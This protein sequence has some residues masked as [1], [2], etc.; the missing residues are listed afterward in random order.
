MS[1]SRTVRSFM[2]LPAAMMAVAMILS[3]GAPSTAQAGIDKYKMSGKWLSRRG[4]AFIPLMAAAAT[5]A[6]IGGCLGGD[7]NPCYLISGG[8]AG[9]GVAS[10]TGA[11]VGKQL[12]IP[13]GVFDGQPLHLVPLG[14]GTRN[15]FGLPANPTVIQVSTQF[16]FNGPKSDGIMK[17]G[18]ANTSPNGR[19]A[20]DFTWC[21]G[22][23]SN[24]ACTAPAQ[25]NP[26]G[27]VRYV[28][29]PRGFG[30]TMRMLLAGGGDLSI[31]V[32]GVTNSVSN[33]VQVIHNV[34]GGG[35][36]TQ[37]YSGAYADSN[38]N[39]LAGGP[40][41]IPGHTMGTIGG[42]PAPVCK[43]GVD[44]ADL[45]TT[46]PGAPG[47][48]G[49]LAYTGVQVAVGPTSTNRNVGFPFS[50]GQVKAQVTVVAGTAP[51][52]FTTTGNDGRG[53]DGGNIVLVAGG[54]TLRG[55]GSSF[56]SLERVSMTLLPVKEGVPAMAPVG[57]VT[58]TT[59][60][61][62]AGGFAL[63]RRSS[64]KS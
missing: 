13:A 36:G 24:P 60:M 35:G 52:T 38:S 27:L 31:K 39:V 51:E 45:T 21:E 41:T 63:R 53:I 61:A 7:A 12:T 55:S 4:T 9:D 11:G 33:P 2:A 42:F 37:I 22:A 40:I 26:N 10:A 23:A 29:G 16:V 8:I 50:T 34:I 25:G 58:F 6:P 62:L 47:G 43:A 59:L 19:L 64:K 20:A 48:P 15:I 49:C 17:S 57:I 3:W 28:A 46:C 5:T 1:S 30:G 18:F 44:C 56:A 32:G 14:A 54:V